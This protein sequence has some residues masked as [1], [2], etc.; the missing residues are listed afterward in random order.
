VL[1]INIVLTV[2]DQFGLLDLVTLV[3]DLV[4]V[5]LVVGIGRTRAAEH[6]ICRTP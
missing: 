4:L 1:G 5:G 3:I 2:T 6:G